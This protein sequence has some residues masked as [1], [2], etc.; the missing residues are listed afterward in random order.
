MTIEEIEDLRQRNY[1]RNLAAG[2][3]EI[4]ARLGAEIM[5]AWLKRYLEEL[6][7]EEREGNGKNRK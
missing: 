1:Q 3:D 2:Y 6:D 7:T 5:I 4:S